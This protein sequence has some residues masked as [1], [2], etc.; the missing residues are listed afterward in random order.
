MKKCGIFLLFPIIVHAEGYTGDASASS[1][2]VGQNTFVSGN[3]SAVGDMGGSFPD[4]S[5][6]IGTVAR[7]EYFAAGTGYSLGG[8]TVDI[9]G[10]GSFL[11]NAQEAIAQTRENAF[12]ETQDGIAGAGT[13]GR[14]TVTIHA[15]DTHASAQGYESSHDI[16]TTNG[17]VMGN[18]TGASASSHHGH[19]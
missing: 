16:T 8:A 12:A 13:F 14:S 17:V 15:A 11:Q 19:F 4:G 2:A 3:V 9:Q 6:H 10:E 5:Y 1:Y 7:S 18:G